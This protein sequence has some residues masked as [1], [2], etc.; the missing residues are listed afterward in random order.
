M[1]FNR[2]GSTDPLDAPV[3]ELDAHTLRA[4]FAGRDEIAVIDVRETGVHTR[5]GHILRSVSL[6]LSHLELRVAG[7]IP[8][9]QTPVVVYDEGSDILARRAVH[10]LRQLGYGDVAVLK[11][12]TRAWH[13]AG[14]ELFS[15][16]NVLGKAFGEF[17][18]VT[19]GTPHLAVGDVK[20]RLEAGENVVVLDSR[21]EPEFLNF[22]IP[23]AIDL[24]GA[25]LV[26]RF[27]AAVPDP[28][29]LVVVNCA[30]RTRSIIGAQALINAGVPNPVASLANGTMDWL[31]EGFALQ[32]G[33]ANLAPL[34]TGE[35]LEAARQAAARLE[36]RFEL[37]VIDHATLAG[38]QE[39]ALAGTRSLY[40]LDVRTRAE[41]EAGHYPG[42]RWAEGGQLVQQTGEWVAT[43]NSRIVLI[44]GPDRV[45]AAITASWL[46]Q[47]NW[48]EVFILD[49]ALAGAVEAGPEAPRYAVHPPLGNIIEA[50]E[51]SGLLEAGAAT[52][53]DL[54]A[55]PAHKAG[56]IAGSRFA[57]RSR[58]ADSLPLAGEGPLVLTSADGVL[59]AFAAADI[60]ERSGRAVR[61]LAGG[62]A[63]WRKA[64][65]PLSADISDPLHPFEA[66]WLTPYQEPDPHAAFRTYLDWEL[67][68]VEQLERDGTTRF[69]RFPSEVPEAAHAAE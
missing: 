2:A 8:R 22:S 35:A 7:L 1:T 32:S 31:L 45:R 62:T 13:E 48:A 24:P 11:G 49:G 68:L 10:R 17:A 30:G 33:K 56:H 18:E 14:G 21:P 29:T 27:H 53:L 54:E 60:A 12:G 58:L 16:S 59:A 43:Q 20:R 38:F 15:G 19:Y 41:Y 40:L 37:S 66:V 63:A 25:E 6:P 64:G 42:A 44:D 9:L 52:V 28:D 61:V 36:K 55:S 3:S 46:A 47:I 69:R 34:P 67:G 65:L 51:L 26:Y 57:I 23:G 39:E 5:D 50:S 4:R